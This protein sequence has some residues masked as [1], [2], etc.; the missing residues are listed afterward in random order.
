[1][2]EFFASWHVPPEGTVP[3]RPLRNRTKP[4]DL[5]QGRRT[6]SAYKTVAYFGSSTF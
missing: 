6:Q 5:R 2:K 4:T 1:M 3:F